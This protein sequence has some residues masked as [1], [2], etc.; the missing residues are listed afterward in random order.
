MQTRRSAS[1][2]HVR[3]TDLRAEV[4]EPS[5]NAARDNNNSRII[6]HHINLGVRNDEELKTIQGGVTIATG[7]VLPNIHTVRM[8]CIKA[9]RDAS[10]EVKECAFCA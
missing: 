5:D 4:F 8:Q 10:Q 7:V 9:K 2:R 6:L 1:G 3:Q